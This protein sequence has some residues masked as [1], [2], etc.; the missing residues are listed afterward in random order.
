MSR[1]SRMNYKERR[2]MRM[3]Q[4]VGGIFAIVIILAMVLSLISNG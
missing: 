4:I 1:K 2:N 3:Q